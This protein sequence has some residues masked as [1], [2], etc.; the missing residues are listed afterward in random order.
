MNSLQ[1]THC[2]FRISAATAAA[3]AGLEDSQIC[4][5][6]RWNSST[7]LAYIRIPQEHLALLT[8]KLAAS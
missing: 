1:D 8:N 4:I 5:L 3:K 2:S 7:F 6:G